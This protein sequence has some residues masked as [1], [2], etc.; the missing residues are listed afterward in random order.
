M[1]NGGLPAKRLYLVK[2]N[3]GVGKTTL[4]IQFLLEGARRGEKTLYITLSE[5]EEEVRQVAASHGWSL[6][7]LELF[8]FVRRGANAEVARREQFVRVRRRR[9]QRGRRRALGAHN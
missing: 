4:S 1:L 2:G 9:S 8:E 5:T 3:P 7:G 6:D